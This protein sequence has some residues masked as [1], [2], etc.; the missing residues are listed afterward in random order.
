MTDEP[1]SLLKPSVSPFSTLHCET[2]AV[3]ARHQRGQPWER[4][5]VY[6]QRGIYR[7][8][9]AIHTLSR[10]GPVRH[11]LA[12]RAIAGTL[13][14]HAPFAIPLSDEARELVEKID[15]ARARAAPNHDR[16]R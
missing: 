7:P 5:R 15:G 3:A 9:M 13:E 11:A 14:V 1:P 6:G 8:T 2:R 10:L 12:Q 4:A 16:D